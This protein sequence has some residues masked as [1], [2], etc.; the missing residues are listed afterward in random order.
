MVFEFNGKSLYNELSH[1]SRGKICRMDAIADTACTNTSIG[2]HSLATLLN[3][4]TED[5]R[6]KLVNSNG[7][8]K[9]META[10]G[11]YHMLIRTVLLNVKLPG[12]NDA[13]RLKRLRCFVNL[14]DQPSESPYILLG[15]DFLL[16]FRQC[17]LEDEKLT[18][19]D[20]DEYKYEKLIDKYSS[21]TTN[22]YSLLGID[23]LQSYTSNS[24][25][26]ELLR[27]ACGD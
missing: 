17:V 18:C 21:T 9:Q 10:D 3:M 24:N 26:S 25:I 1:Y 27:Q 6:N 16:M 12:V 8:L 23:S 13:N 15:L 7:S 19:S 20:F 2:S 22:I 5:V 14:Q 11:S 4:D